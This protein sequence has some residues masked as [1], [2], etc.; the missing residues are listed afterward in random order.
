MFHSKSIK[1][2]KQLDKK[3]MTRLGHFLDSP[4]FF[5]GRKEQ[6]LI[7]LFCYLQRY[8]PR[9]QNKKLAR[10]EVFVHLFPN[11]NYKEQTLQQLMTKF[12]KA[13]ENFIAHS[14][15]SKSFGAFP[16]PLGLAAFY[17]EKNLFAEYNKLYRHATARQAKQST[18]DPQ[19]Y[20]IDFLWAKEL[21]EQESLYNL[22]QLDLNLPQTHSR[23]DYFFLAAKLELACALVDQQ[24]HHA[25]ISEQG[26][27]K[28]LEAVQP[29]LEA[30]LYRE[31]PLIDLLYRAYQ[32]LKEQSTFKEYQALQKDFD[33]YAM[34]IGFNQRQVIFA[35][36]KNFG[37]KK[38]NQGQ[39]DY[40]EP[41][42]LLYQEGLAQGV[43]IFGGGLLPSTF[44][45]IVLLGIRLKKY[46][47]VEIFLEEYR[48]Q[49]VQAE[50]PESTYRL[51][52]ASL[53]FATGSY[54]E[55][56]D[57]LTYEFTDIYLKLMARR[58][59]VQI[60]FEL[61]S[62]LLE[63]KIKAFKIF[64]YRLPKSRITDL[65]REGYNN[66]I[67]LLK[68]LAHPNTRLKT[69][70]QS[71]LIEKIKAKKSVAERQWLLD[72]LAAMD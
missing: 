32:L 2:L 63:A 38:L 10:E 41:L 16:L 23:L 20:W 22:R 28:I 61:Q 69:F 8:Y 48:H 66:F 9:F 49:L 50:A 72:K 39:K 11:K 27:L 4:F 14:Y 29:L 36:L 42:F 30:G 15:Q 54:D 35:L 56:L 21:T 65:Q 58:L 46:K 60:Y 24:I 71:S 25:P 59:E 45:S 40:L 51:N 64:I 31:E 57:C 55:A 26:A 12:N 44:Q 53:L 17:R 43:M 33:K 5:K 19:H 6:P 13:V 37:I 18:K 47:W 67:D 62:T 70:R 68:Q 7:D 52:R 1:L 3:E 34:R